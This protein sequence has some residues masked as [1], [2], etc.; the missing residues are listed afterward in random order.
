MP[1][2]AQDL[3]ST[4]ETPA[5]RPRKRRLRRRSDRLIRLL[6]VMAIFGAVVISAVLWHQSLTIERQRALIQQ[7]YQDNLELN[8]KRGE[9]Q[10][11]PKKSSADTPGAGPYADGC[12]VH[13]GPCT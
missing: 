5:A 13:S 8:K 10:K 2:P 4:F 3:T 7:I 12:M 1:L 9:S 11:Q 6:A